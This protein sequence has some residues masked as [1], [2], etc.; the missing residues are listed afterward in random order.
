MPSVAD[1][2]AVASPWRWTD[3]GQL[4]VRDRDVEIRFTTRLGGV[5]AGP[6]RSLDLG[7]WGQD[8][9]ADVAENRATVAG[10]AG[11]RLRALAQPRQVH[12][13][14]VLLLGAEDPRPGPGREREADGICTAVRGLP[15]LVVSADCLPIVL[16]APGAFAVV[17]AGWRGL[18]AGVLEAAVERLATAAGEAA[19]AVAEL[20]AWIGPGA[21]PCCYQVGPEVHAAF[22]DLGPGVRAGDHLDLPAAARE[23]LRRAGVGGVHEAGLCTIH[24]PALFFSHRRDGE[25]T[26]RQGVVAWRT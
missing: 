10:W 1:L 12:G 25:R 14:E 17:H 2:P 6:F 4:A 21:G 16:V 8:D 19:D 18:A 22:A 9:A 15:A 11:A 13:T 23:R 3:D 26:G 24:R 7:P 5:S 20:T